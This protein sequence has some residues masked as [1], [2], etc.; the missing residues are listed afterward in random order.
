MKMYQRPD[1]FA[2]WSLAVI[3]LVG[4][5]IYLVF[6]YTLDPVLARRI[7]DFEIGIVGLTLL[8]DCGHLIRYHR[9]S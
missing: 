5:S 3:L 2:C 7:F 1:G 4:L 6:E 9:R 8:M